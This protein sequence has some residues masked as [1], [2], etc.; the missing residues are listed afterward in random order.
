MIHQ[1]VVMKALAL[2][3]H[4]APFGDR[5][6]HAEAEIADRRAVQQHEHRVG[7][8]E[9]ERAGDGVRQQMA[10]HDARRG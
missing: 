4:D 10:E 1:A 5:R 2:G 9:D 8:G 7:H 3:D 6:L